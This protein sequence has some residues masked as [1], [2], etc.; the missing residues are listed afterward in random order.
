MKCKYCGRLVTTKAIKVGHRY[1]CNDIC[2]DMQTSIDE[3][4]NTRIRNEQ[5]KKTPKI[6]TPLGAD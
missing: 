3:F 5:E 2:L 4:I 1:F 6:D